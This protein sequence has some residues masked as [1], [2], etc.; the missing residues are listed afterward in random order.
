MG[1]ASPVS[2]RAVSPPN[3]AVE[4]KG[5]SVQADKDTAV[6]AVRTFL[7]PRSPAAALPS[8]AATPLAVTAHTPRT[9][10]FNYL[11]PVHNRCPPA[12]LM[13]SPFSSFAD[14]LVESKLDQKASPEPW[15]AQPAAV[16]VA[17]TPRRAGI[18]NTTPNPRPRR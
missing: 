8:A 5:P 7:P 14:E 17:A 6:P 1:V 2:L 9:S 18:I 4:T 15:P 13:F 10:V 11:T 12:G 3:A 16:A